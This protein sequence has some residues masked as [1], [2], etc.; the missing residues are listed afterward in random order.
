MAAP[1]GSQVQVF[2]LDDVQFPAIPEFYAGTVQLSVIGTDVVLT[3]SRPRTA[4]VDMGD[5]PIQVAT[6]NPVCQ[7]TMSI[8]SSKEFLLVLDQTV[9]QY[10]AIN[11]EI[12]T[13]FTRQRSANK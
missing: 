13:E 5:G 8:L 6:Q 2:S 1:D 11:G 4:F 10:E 9:S 12:V 3:F 7:L